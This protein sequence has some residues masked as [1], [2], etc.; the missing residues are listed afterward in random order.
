MDINIS[1]LTVKSLEYR[2]RLCTSWFSYI[3][4]ISSYSIYSGEALTC[5]RSKYES[6]RNLATLFIL[7]PPMN[8]ISL[9]YFH[10]V[11]SFP[12]VHSFMHATKPFQKQLWKRNGLKVSS[13]QTIR[14]TTKQFPHD[15]LLIVIPSR[16]SYFIA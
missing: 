9:H 15:C 11:K 7:L 12:C 1:I 5:A 3:H 16:S 14:C 2:R 8:K 4:Q 6:W 13:L 10:P